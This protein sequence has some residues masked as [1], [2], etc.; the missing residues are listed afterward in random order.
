MK[1]A[2][3]IL[4]SHNKFHINLGLNRIK[5]VMALLGNPQNNYKIITK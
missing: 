4:T 3:E 2:Q 1:K 5:Q